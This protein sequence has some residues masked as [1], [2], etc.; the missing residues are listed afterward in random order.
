MKKLSF[1]LLI[2]ISLIKIE[3][4]SFAYLYPNEY[5]NKA[6]IECVYSPPQNNVNSYFNFNLSHKEYV[7]SYN[8][9]KNSLAVNKLSLLYFNEYVTSR[10]KLTGYCFKSI[11]IFK[12]IPQSNTCRNSV[13][14]DPLR[15][16]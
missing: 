8:S 11:S 1:L 13:D 2:F 6:N 3:G 15:L 12:K 4:A 5:S 16:S 14:E 7:K 10:L 9:N